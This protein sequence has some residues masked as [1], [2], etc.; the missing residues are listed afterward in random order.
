MEFIINNNTF[1]LVIT[2]IFGLISLT[3]LLFEIIF[4]HHVKMTFIQRL[5][6][7]IGLK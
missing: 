5:L 1:E 4:Y 6:V 3:Y 2:S 7:N